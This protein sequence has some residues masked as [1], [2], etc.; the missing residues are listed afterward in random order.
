MNDSLRYKCA[1]RSLLSTIACY[2]GNLGKLEHFASEIT[3][4][5]YM[6]LSYTLRTSSFDHNTQNIGKN[7]KR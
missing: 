5:L 3:N 1:I 2:K 7:A 6:Q 4:K